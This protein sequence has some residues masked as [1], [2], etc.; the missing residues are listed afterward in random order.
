MTVEARDE[1]LREDFRLRALIAAV[2]VGV[3]ALA[4]FLLSSSGA[5]EVRR[6]LSASW[7]TWPL[8]IA[9]ASAEECPVAKV[10][11]ELTPV[12]SHK[13]KDGAF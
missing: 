7:W 2:I 3:L 5:P 10:E 1:N 12:R 13:V 9:T 4:V 6:D 8:Q 11:A